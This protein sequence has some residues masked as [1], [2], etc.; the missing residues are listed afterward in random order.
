MR[1]NPESKTESAH[2]DG[3]SETEIVSVSDFSCKRADVFTTKE[4][5]LCCSTPIQSQLVII[6]SKDGACS[7]M[8][9]ESSLI[10]LGIDNPWGDIDV[11]DIPMEIIS[12]PNDT[13]NECCM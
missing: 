12:D 6:S 2:S 4:N 8:S 1:K 7:V 5:P 9:E 11:A 3:D 13:D 10:D